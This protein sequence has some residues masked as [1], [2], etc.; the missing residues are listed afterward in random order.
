MRLPFSE[1]IETGRTQ[2][3]THV[4]SRRGDSFGAFKLRHPRTGKIYH[5][6]AAADEGWDHVS[7]SRPNRT[8]P[9]WDE[10]CWVK[11]LFF[12]PEETVVQYHPAKGKNVDRYPVLHLWRP[13][14]VELP[15][16]P[17]IFV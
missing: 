14:D 12:L 16:P 6:M 10:M 11:D 2:V 8:L 5:V 7:V 3:R 1:F 13:Q 9:T 15:M 4:R 17:I